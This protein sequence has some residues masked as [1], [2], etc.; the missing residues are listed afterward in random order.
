MTRNLLFNTAFH[1]SALA[2][3]LATTSVGMMAD[4]QATQKIMDA[5]GAPAC[6]SCHA[7]GAYT[8]A[9]GKAGLAAF[10][11]AKTPTCVA[12]KV[13]QNNVC[14]TPVTIPTCTAPQV[15]QTNVCVTPAATPT[16]TAPQVLQNNVCVTPAATPTCTA[17][18]V[19]QNNVCVTPATT[20][21]GTLTSQDG[22]ESDENESEDNDHDS[23]GY[24]SDDDDR[25]SEKSLAK[26]LP[27]L[28]APDQVSVH[29]GEP[30]TLAVTAFDCADRPITIVASPLPKGASIEN[31]IDPEL[32]MPKA[33][34]TWTP[35]VG[36][37]G[38]KTLVLKAIAN[39]SKT[40]KTTSAPQTVLIEVLPAVPAAITT[41]DNLVKKNTVASARFNA[42]TQ[43]IEVSGQI[44]WEKASTKQNR[45]ALIAAETAVV[46]DAA[47]GAQLALAQVD[48]TGKWKATFAS[49]EA[50][51]PCSVD[52]SFHGKTDVKG[53]KGI[54]RCNLK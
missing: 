7:G 32:H 20:A 15:L 40:K 45:L 48:K 14:V 6:K 31:S 1:K 17:P 11:A 36:A 52:V 21:C 28:S 4:A 44:A 3:L 39:D 47:N 10:L 18:Q 49:T 35:P 50:L 29:A 19:L 24:K 13:L 25:K 42:K 2:L 37:E 51:A 38:K 22:D 41:P 53:V 43:K 33:V 54:K 27:T 9:E 30:L 12:P 8:K 23:N 34:I 26:T 46:N 16:C 5:N